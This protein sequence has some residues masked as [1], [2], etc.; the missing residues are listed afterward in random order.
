MDDL[1]YTPKSTFADAFM[2]LQSEIPLPMYTLFDHFPI[3]KALYHNSTCLV[4]A[5]V[6]FMSL[7]V[8]FVLKKY[9]DLMQDYAS[10]KQVNL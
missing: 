6:M 10:L 9:K 5:V 8:G 7:I 4:L 1:K 2:N 3:I